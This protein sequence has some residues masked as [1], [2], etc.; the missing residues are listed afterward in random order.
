MVKM[1]EEKLLVR[2]ISRSYVIPEG[3]RMVIEHVEECNKDREDENLI[4]WVR[5]SNPETANELQVAIRTALAFVGC[6]RGCK[7]DKRI[8]QED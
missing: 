6:K 4:N 3:V 1:E 8:Q 2:D 5:Q 7:M